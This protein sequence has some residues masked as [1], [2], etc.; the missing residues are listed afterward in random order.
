MTDAMDIIRT[1]RKRKHLNTA[2][3]HNIYKV[4]TDNLQMKNINTYISQYLEHYRKGT[5]VS[6]QYAVHPNYQQR[7]FT[8]T[9]TTNNRSSKDI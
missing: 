8:E 2:K 9:P 6:T 1:H 4:S 7:H 5:P 3:K